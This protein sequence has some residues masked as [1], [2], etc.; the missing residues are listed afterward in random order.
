MHLHIII[1]VSASKNKVVRFSHP[2]VS[3]AQLSQSAL[4]FPNEKENGI[5]Q[6]EAA[7]TT[8]K[9][10]ANSKKKNNSV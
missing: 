5:E 7:T 2:K 6:V 8:I 9:R 3:S 1:I 4:K 10:E